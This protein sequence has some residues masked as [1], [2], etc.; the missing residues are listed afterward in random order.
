M[1]N[2]WSTIPD[3]SSPE[4]YATVKVFTAL[5]SHCIH[6]I[7]SFSATGGSLINAALLL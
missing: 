1:S 4:G 2:Q 7:N 3:V 5:P 6:A